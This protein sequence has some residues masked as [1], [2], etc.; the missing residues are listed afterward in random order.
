LAHPELRGQ[1]AGRISEANAFTPLG[2]SNAQALDFLDTSEGMR[3]LEHLRAAAPNLDTETLVRRALEQVRSGITLPQ[4]RT[5]EEPLIKLVPHGQQLSEVSPYLT[6]EGEVARLLNGGGS[7]TDGFGLPVASEAQSY[8]IY[9]FRP[10]GRAEVFVSE[11]APTEELGGA[12]RRG[13]LAMQ[14]LVPDRSQFHPGELIGTVENRLAR[15]QVYRPL[16]APVEQAVEAPHLA[17]GLRGGG[18]ALGVAGIAL[19][20]YDA[21]DTGF[22]IRRHA[23]EGNA[24]AAQS[25]AIHFGGRVG[26]IAGSDPGIAACAG[27]GVAY[28]NAGVLPDACVAAVRI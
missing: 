2:V 19:T 11:I 16:L 10:N 4:M 24:T 5:V 26:R 13:G 9:A 27:V 22:N 6:R 21:A 12:V 18:V 7:I 20:L 17:P 8:D 1:Q 28:C 15:G 3:Y 14:T 23:A 25:E